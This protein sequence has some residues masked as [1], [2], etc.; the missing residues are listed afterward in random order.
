MIRIGLALLLL[1]CVAPLAAGD[2]DAK[3][4]LHGLLAEAWE[5]DLVENPLL[6]SAT[7]DHRFDDRLPSMT[8]ADLERRASRSRQTLDRLLAIDSADL[9]PADRV[10]RRMLELQLRDDLD[11]HRFGDWRIPLTSDSGFH[12]GIALLP[13]E[14]PLATVR[15]YENYIA[16]LR[17][18]PAYFD[19]HV[20]LLREG[21]RTGFTM[22][23]VVLEG[24]DVTIRTHAIAEPEKS[25]FWAPF[26]VPSRPA[27]RRGNGSGSSPPGGRSSPTRSSRR[28]ARSSTS[29]PASTC[30][31]RERRR[32]PPT[33]PRG[34]PTTSGGCATTRR[35]TPRRTRST[36]SG[37]GR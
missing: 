14:V 22:P 12:T 23:R 16:R 27:S 25:V 13:R 37:S 4:R 24:Y 9:A 32:R 19:Q 21:L 5:Q 26:E 15:D 7:G 29:S 36:R 11:A 28:T 35:S 6:A 18:V 17:A 3:K 34:G 8:A 1:G 31:G 20:A 33:S 2:A 10:S 30:R